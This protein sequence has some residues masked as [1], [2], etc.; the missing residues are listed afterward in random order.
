MTTLQSLWELKRTSD[1]TYE[2]I[3][4]GNTDKC[5]IFNNDIALLLALDL[6]D[7]KDDTTRLFND[8]W[9]YFYLDTVSLSST[10][11][12]S[13]DADTFYQYYVIRVL[14][15]R[16]LPDETLKTIRKLQIIRF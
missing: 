11:Q 4:M 13:I 5:L 6:I 14:Q 9:D 2:Q 10:V 15:V 3:E 12:E 1:S 7:T 16:R 8:W